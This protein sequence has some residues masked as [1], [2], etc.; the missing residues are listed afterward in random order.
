LKILISGNGV[1]AVTAAQTLSNEPGTEITILGREPHLYY[2]RPRLWS[3]IAG[4]IDREDLFA[5]K[6]EWYDENNIEV[7]LGEEAVEIFPEERQVRTGSGVSHGYDKLLLATGASAFV[8]PIEG[9]SLAG[10]FSLRTLEDA[11]AIKAHASQSQKAAVIG[12]GLLGLE[13]ARVLL[14][15]GLEVTVLE[16]AP[17]LLPQQLDEQ[18]AGLLTSLLQEMGMRVRS[19]VRVEKVAGEEKVAEVLLAEGERLAADLVLLSTGIRSNV[20]LA[21][22]AGLA[23]NRG[24]LV[25]QNMRTSHEGI[26][27]AGDSA[28]FDGRVYGIIPA[29]M[30]QA[31]AAAAAML[32]QQPDYTGTIPSTNLKVTGISLTSM[33]EYLGECDG[34]QEYRVLDEEQRIY[35]KVVIKD[36]VIRGTIL[37]NDQ[38][39]SGPISQLI[40]SGKDISGHEQDIL[41]DEFDI[42]TLSHRQIKT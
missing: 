27:A 2:S 36:G 38:A 6:Q 17:R 9:R 11:E 39:R 32:G 10:V 4:E 7:L 23:V 37:V 29:A 14:G 13:I 3:Y 22:K 30:E 41:Q 20:E 42:K 1:A 5:R 33:G 31:R 26:Y 35:R 40:R 8:P 16:A 28:E 34:C 25:D 18:G 19:G 24:V 12:G 15:L 21:K